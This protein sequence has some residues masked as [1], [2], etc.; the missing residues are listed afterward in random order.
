MN[1]RGIKKAFGRVKQDLVMTRKSLSGVI[2]SLSNEYAKMRLRMQELE[3]RVAE[4]EE[5]R[6]ETGS[7]SEYAK[8]Y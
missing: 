1:T 6:V 7:A 3:T 8:S 4:L 5:Q 2:F